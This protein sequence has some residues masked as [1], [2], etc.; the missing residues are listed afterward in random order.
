[1]RHDEFW[2]EISKH[3]KPTRRLVLEAGDLGQ[4]PITKIG[5]MP[6][7][8]EGRAR[9]RCDKGHL[10]SFMAQIKLSDVPGILPVDEAL[11]SFHYCQ[12]CT[13]E[14]NMSFGLADPDHAC[15]GYDLTLFDDPDAVQPDRLGIV[16]EDVLGPN[17]VRFSDR[18]ETPNLED[19]WNIEAISLLLPHRTTD[20]HE[21]D[22][23]FSD[24]YP[25][26]EADYPDFIHIP[27]SKVGGWPS[28][29]QSPEWPEHE[30]RRDVFVA[31]LDYTLSILASWGG[32]GYAYLFLTPEGVVP[33]RAEFLIQTT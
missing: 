9:P 17:M 19:I 30:G 11:L 3:Q 32:G 25:F 20:E 2:Q 5:G 4:M 31:Q 22:C 23:I 27:T 16:A 15:E 6:W 10:M 24:A 29:A 14:G 13:Y 1:M 12:E 21:L 7:W 28:W 33:R 8:P 26:N 18:D